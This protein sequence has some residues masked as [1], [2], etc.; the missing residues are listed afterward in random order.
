MVYVVGSAK[1]QPHL[2]LAVVAPLWLVV[3]FI[4]FQGHYNSSLW[5]ALDFFV[6]IELLSHLIILLY[7]VHLTLSI[8]K[9]TL[10]Q[11]AR[12]G[13]TKIFGQVSPNFSIQ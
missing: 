13:R 2:H 3:N 6:N 9:Y 7:K 10:L 1:V 5:L 12:E 4:Y 11:F 8:V